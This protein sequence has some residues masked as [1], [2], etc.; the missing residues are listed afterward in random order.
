[1][2]PCPQE[3]LTLPLHTWLSTSIATVITI[4]ALR[5]TKRSIH[6]LSCSTTQQLLN[7][8]V[9]NYC[10]TCVFSLSHFGEPNICPLNR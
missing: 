10:V 4:K 1:M 9:L 5:V 8:V 2:A 7:M 3:A 6:L